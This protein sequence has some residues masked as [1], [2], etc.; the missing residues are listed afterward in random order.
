MSSIIVNKYN[1]DCIT[2]QCGCIGSCSYFTFY[3]IANNCFRVDVHIGLDRRKHKI[4][5]RCNKFLSNFI[6]DNNDLHKF[7][8]T[9]TVLLIT[10]KED[11]SVEKEIAKTHINFSKCG[12]I[13][14]L[15]FYNKA[16]DVLKNKYA[17]DIILTKHMYTKLVKL[18]SNWLKPE[19]TGD[20]L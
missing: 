9:S 3:K 11:Y 10:K 7:I 4:I 1:N 17:Y 14:S 6:L 5:R 13:Y 15:V 20:T 18:L 16:K 2:I 12:D 8:N 19:V